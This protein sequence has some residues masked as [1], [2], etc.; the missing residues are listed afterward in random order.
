MTETPLHQYKLQGK[1]WLYQ[2]K[3]A[4]HFVTLPKKQSAAISRFFGSLKRGWG[5][6]PVVVTIGR[7]SWKTSIF[8]DSKAGAYILP[9]KAEVREKERIRS[10]DTIRFRIEVR[11]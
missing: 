10:G 5:S 3:A 6:L 11:P 9:L 4:W 8:P 2:G 7:T 1:V